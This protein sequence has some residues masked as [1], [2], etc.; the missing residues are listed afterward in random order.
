MITE[1]IPDPPGQCREIYTGQAP[2]IRCKV[3]VY[4]FKTAEVAGNDPNWRT[5]TSCR[6]AVSV[7]Y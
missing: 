4:L 1:H 7:R 2:V 5:E 6:K 3:E